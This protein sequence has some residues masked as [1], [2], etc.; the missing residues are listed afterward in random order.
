[1][2]G[3]LRRLALSI[4]ACIF[5]IK[6]IS[7]TTNDRFMSVL[8]PCIVV[9]RPIVRMK[10]QSESHITIV[11]RSQAMQAYCTVQPCHRSRLQE[12]GSCPSDFWVAHAGCRTRPEIVSQFRW[13]A[14][15]ILEKNSLFDQHPE[16]SVTQNSCQERIVPVTQLLTILSASMMVCSRWATVST[17]VSRGS[18]L[19]KDACITASVSWS[20]QSSSTKGSG[21][22]S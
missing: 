3:Q 6:Q 17:V 22:E 18:S 14:N 16:P 12:H 15:G 19:R 10:K 2:K 20:S 9:L 5:Q 11:R 7:E 1:M 21:K 13:H 4:G 8:D